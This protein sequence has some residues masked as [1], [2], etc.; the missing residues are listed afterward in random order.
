MKTPKPQQGG[1]SHAKKIKTLKNIERPII[2]EFKTNFYQGV[3][4]GFSK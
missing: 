3:F 2:A 1:T 4:Y